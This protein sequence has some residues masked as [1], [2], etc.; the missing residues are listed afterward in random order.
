MTSHRQRAVRESLPVLQP[1]SGQVHDRWCFIHSIPQEN[2]VF[3]SF[4]V[5]GVLVGQEA[6]IR[7]HI[8][9]F[10]ISNP[11]RIFISCTYLSIGYLF[12]FK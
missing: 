8:H 11:S 5:L 2:V 10:L 7:I 3:L 1:A 9:L 6:T 12:A 4:S